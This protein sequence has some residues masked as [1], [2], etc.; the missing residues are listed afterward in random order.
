MDTTWVA[1]SVSCVLRILAVLKTSATRMDV[2]SVN[3]ATTKM[4]PSALLVNLACRAALNVIQETNALSVNHLSLTLI[5]RMVD[6]NA[7]EVEKIWGLTT[8]GPVCAKLD[9]GLQRTVASFVKI[10]YLV[11]PNVIR[12][13]VT[14]WSLFTITQQWVPTK[15]QEITS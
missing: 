10:S 13:Q 15:V 4:V 5:Q 9:T 3:Q 6:V 7:M 14:H 8:R 1:G 11:A 12:Q 2:K